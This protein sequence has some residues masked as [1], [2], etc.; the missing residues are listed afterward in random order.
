MEAREAEA[1]ATSAEGRAISGRTRVYV[2]LAHPSAHVRTPQTFNR[3]FRRR[4]LDAVAV[5]IDVAPGDLS[6]LVRGL[7]GWRNL[8]GIGVTMPHKETIVADLDEMLGTSRHIGAANA[9]RREPD[10][11]LVGLNTDGAGFVLGLRAAG[12]DPRDL[13]ALLVGVGGAGRA[14]AWSLIEAGVGHL[15]LWNRTGEKAEALARQIREVLPAAQVETGSADPS[16]KDLVINATSLGMHDDAP[17]PVDV[18]RLTPGM[19]VSDIIMSPPRTRLI[20]EAERRG[21]AVQPGMPMLTYQV[22]LVLRF[23]RLVPDGDIFPAS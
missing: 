2:H 10:G 22:E 6:P 19:V 20:E 9:V 21:C 4:G 5:S 18:S 7:R 11:R 23:L 17:L 16:G 1:L 13:R 3:E 8:A 12:H 14:I 15:T